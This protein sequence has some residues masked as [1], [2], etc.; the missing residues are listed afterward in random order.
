MK[1]K[2]SLTLVG[3]LAAT[4]PAMP[5]MADGGFYVYGAAGLTDTAGRKGQVDTT[6]TNLGVT[7]FT[8]QADEKDQGYKLQVG[9]RLT[10]HFAI[11]G[12]YMDL[13]RYT[14]DAVATVPAATRTGSGT[15]DAW[16]IGVVGNLP[17]NDR[18]SLFGRLG[19][20]AHRLKFH[21]DGTGIPCTNPDRTARG[22]SLHYGAGLQW[23]LTRNLFVRG[24]YEVIRDIGDA[25]N[26][27]GTTGTSEADLK[28]GS[29]GLGYRF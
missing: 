12:G 26:F 22:N 3:L 11:E 28:M 20:A 19:V 21:C 23:A 10:P 7:A 24:E 13:G 9:Y 15:I 6:I 8:S 5:A 29:I 25:F 18:F 2:S 1:I 27:T 14:Y 4:L 16:N 17:L